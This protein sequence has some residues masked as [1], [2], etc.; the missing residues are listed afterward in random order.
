MLVTLFKDPRYRFLIVFSSALIAGFLLYGRPLSTE[1]FLGTPKIIGAFFIFIAWIMSVYGWGSRLTQLLGL[2]ELP[3]SASI[4]IGL[5]L[6]SIFPQIIYLIPG[7]KLGTKVLAFNTFLVYGAYICN[8]R[9]TKINFD[10]ARP[11]PFYLF[12][13]GL[14]V[15]GLVNLVPNAFWDS[16][17][18]H[19]SAVRFWFN[20]DQLIFNPNAVAYANASNFDYLFFWP[21]IL[22]SKPGN[23]GL[24]AINLFGQW[25]HYFGAV[26]PC[27]LFVGA[28]L[29]QKGESSKW[30]LLAL[31]FALFEFT[32]HYSSL[33]AKND[34]G[35]LFWFLLAFYLIVECKQKGFVYLV[36]G[37]FLLGYLTAAKVTYG[38]FVLIFLL[39]DG[40]SIWKACGFKKVAILGLVLCAPVMALFIRNYV[41]TGSPVFPVPNSIFPTS[42]L[43]PTWLDAFEYYSLD[44]QG[45]SW[46][47]FFKK[48]NKL[49]SEVFVFSLF[50]F[51]YPF[52]RKNNP[53][54]IKLWLLS[55]LGIL[56]IYF[57]FGEDLEFRLIGAVPFLFRVFCVLGLVCVV[58]KFIS[59]NWIHQLIMGLMVL[60]LG[61]RSKAFQI[62]VVD[63]LGLIHLYSKYG[64][65]FNKLSQS[66]NGTGYVSLIKK[67]LK[68]DEKVF[69]LSDIKLFY[70]SDVGAI[71]VWDAPELDRFF[72]N[73]SGPEEVIRELIRRNGRF[74][75]ESLDSIDR[76]FY[77]PKVIELVEFLKEYPHAIVPHSSKSEWVV[78]LK[79][80]E[81]SL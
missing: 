46:L 72:R 26:I 24:V 22:L 3:P 40:K 6:F 13:F 68:K 52:F 62:H 23:S 25:I 36:I 76:Y 45:L 21:N 41:W 43:G 78:D 20:E 65:D 2:K 42:H 1:E 12:S 19:L 61:V 14:I 47:N 49:L 39:L 29:K 11:W 59:K 80:L 67:N 54:M 56:F 60:T 64:G 16:H 34:W 79:L 28:W 63:P 50:Y 10:L 5:V 48:S 9:P 57:G 38:F 77:R 35:V 4:A 73:S 8:Y 7:L 51:C 30:I 58:E 53:A 74:L 31:L 27:L 17:W 55:F 15:V 71:R 69:I 18:Y 70:L 32:L 81:V 37:F 44:W 66:F 75:V 33:A